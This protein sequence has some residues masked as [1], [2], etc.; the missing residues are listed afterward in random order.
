MRLLFTYVCKCVLRARYKD[1]P[2]SPCTSNPSSPREQRTSWHESLLHLTGSHYLVP[3]YTFRYFLFFFPPSHNQNKDGTCSPSLSPHV[4]CL[5]LA[6]LLVRGPVAAFPC[7]YIAYVHAPRYRFSHIEHRGFAS[8]V[9]Q[10]FQTNACFPPPVQNRL[11]RIILSVFV[12]LDVV[13][14]GYRCSAGLP[15]IAFATCLR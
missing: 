12:E 9:G 6:P 13:S 3:M 14:V 2:T 7:S 11:D 1:W 10:H 15:S 5:V 8:A 4:T